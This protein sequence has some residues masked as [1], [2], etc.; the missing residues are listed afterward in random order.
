MNIGQLEAFYSDPEELK[1]T[2]VFVREKDGTVKLAVANMCHVIFEADHKT[3]R[4]AK[5]G[6]EPKPDELKLSALV[7][8]S[9][10]F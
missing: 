1:K 5:V 3:I 10:H 8:Q 2:P 7:F 6:E 4:V 9:G